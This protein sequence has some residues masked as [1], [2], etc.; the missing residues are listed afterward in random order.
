METPESPAPSPSPSPDFLI[1]W[2]RVGLRI[3]ISN[4]LPGV[5]VASGQEIRCEALLQAV[6]DLPRLPAWSWVQGINSVNILVGLL[7]LRPLR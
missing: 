4:E 1:Q 6:G 5:A 7:R 2:S 3:C